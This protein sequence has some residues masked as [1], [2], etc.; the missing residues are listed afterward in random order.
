M[1][2]RTELPRCLPALLPLGSVAHTG[3]RAFIRVEEFSHLVLLLGLEGDVGRL[4]QPVLAA[5]LVDAGGLG[6]H[7]VLLVI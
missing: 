1:G 6:Q 5:V 4:H 2:H 3:D 7:L